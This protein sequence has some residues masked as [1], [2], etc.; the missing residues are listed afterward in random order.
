MSSSSEVTDWRARTVRL[1]TSPG[2]SGRYCAQRFQQVG[3]ASRNQV[4]GARKILGRPVGQAF[5]DQGHQSFFERVRCLCDPGRRVRVGDHRPRG[6]RCGCQS[7]GAQLA[8]GDVG[9]DVFE[10]VGFID[11]DR[12]VFWEDVADSDVDRVEVQVDDEHVGLGRSPPRL[13]SETVFADRTAGRPRAFISSNAHLLPGPVADIGEFRT[14]AGVAAVGEG[15]QRLEVLSGKARQ[16][17]PCGGPAF[18]DPEVG[19]LLCL[20]CVGS[21][22]R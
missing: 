17:R 20:R 2:A 8:A 3:G 18:S 1:S 7:R 21:P 10:L 14:V 11:H 13:L 16:P 9:Q 5:P 4:E 15:S 19:T 6:G 12:V 22:P